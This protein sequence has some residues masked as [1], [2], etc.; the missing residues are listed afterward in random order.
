MAI[1]QGGFERKS[2]TSDEIPSSSLADIAFRAV[3]HGPIFGANL[4]VDHGG[5][6]DPAGVKR[7]PARGWIKARAVQDNSRLAANIQ[8][9]NHF[10]FELT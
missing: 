9:L 2:K 4:D 7:L 10:R 3:E 6:V 5:F 8:K 1:K